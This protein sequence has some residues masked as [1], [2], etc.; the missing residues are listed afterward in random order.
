MC[1]FTCDPFSFWTNSTDT[2][3]VILFSWLFYFLFEIFYF[4]FCWSFK[5]L[6][7]KSYKI[8][9]QIK[10]TQWTLAR[11]QYHDERI[12]LTAEWFE[13][14]NWIE[15]NVFILLSS[16]SSSFTS[17]FFLFWFW[18]K[19]IFIQEEKLYFQCC[20]VLVSFIIDMQY[21]VGALSNSNSIA[22]FYFMIE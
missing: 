14:L 9:I 21:S 10:C 12:Q 8:H 15:L 22:W 7:H 4:I 16:S 19:P 20:T 6:A 13:R 5:L 11:Y 17:F 18:F 2:N 1:M 3:L